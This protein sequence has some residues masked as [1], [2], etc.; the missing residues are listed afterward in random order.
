MNWEKWIK[1]SR[2]QREGQRDRGKGGE[3]E[4]EGD[5]GRGEIRGEDDVQLDSPSS[6]SSSTSA[7][8]PFWMPITKSTSQ[9]SF[10]PLSSPPLPSP[11]LSFSSSI[12]LL[13]FYFCKIEIDL[14]EWLVMTNDDAFALAIDDQIH[15]VH[16]VTHTYVENVSRNYL[17]VQSEMVK[18]GERRGRGGG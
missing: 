6:P 16:H 18:E 2:R 5:R 4:R 15:E 7:S 9:S 12:S 1:G 11:L 10:S 3:G 13:T 8:N 14:P 17:Y